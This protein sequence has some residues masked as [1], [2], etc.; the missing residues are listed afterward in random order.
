MNCDFLPLPNWPYRRIVW[1][2]ALRSVRSMLMSPQSWSLLAESLE[3]MAVDG[4][5][6][7]RHVIERTDPRFQ[8]LT[9]SVPS[10]LEDVVNACDSPIDAP[11]DSS[12]VHIIR[13]IF[14][15]STAVFETLSLH[16][17]GKG[18]KGRN[19]YRVL[20]DCHLSLAVESSDE[21][22][23]NRDT[24]VIS[25]YMR[26]DTRHT[27][28]RYKLL[29]LCIQRR[30]KLVYY[31]KRAGGNAAMDLEDSQ[32]EGLWWVL[33]LRSICWW[34]SIEVVCPA[35]NIASEYYYSQL[36]IYIT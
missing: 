29:Q 10:L 32:I 1:P 8:P 18:I 21:A 31:F 25:G 17:T 12:K 7:S 6:G 16:A 2:I 11:L 26:T 27:N 14:R 19:P 30:S 15:E 28:F 4:D 23:E 33:L 36:P 24:S 5:A 9:K 13:Q 3:T 22:Y 35:S 20:V 34:A